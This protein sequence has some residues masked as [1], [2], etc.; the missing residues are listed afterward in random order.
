MIF[1][2]GSY[3]F[4]SFE[5]TETGLFFFSGQFLWES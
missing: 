1:S 4:A 3:T 2:R 5:E